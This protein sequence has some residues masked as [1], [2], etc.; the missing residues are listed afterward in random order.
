MNI[1]IHN[2]K[3]NK[4]SKLKFFYITIEMF[5]REINSVLNLMNEAIRSGFIVIVGDRQSFL[6]IIDSLPKGILFYKSASIVDEFYYNAFFKRGHKC[7][8]LDAEGLVVH[9]FK[10]FFFKNRLTKKNLE[11]LEYYFC[12]GSY[13]KKIASNLF[14]EFKNKFKTTGSILGMDWIKLKKKTAK[15]YL[16]FLT[17]FGNYN[18]ISGIKKLGID[19]QKRMYQMD[20]KTYGY[21]EKYYNY[22]NI[23]FKDYLEIIPLIADDI[24]PLKIIIKVHPAENIEPWKRIAKLKKNIILDLKNPTDHLISNAS[25]V[26]QSESTTALQTALIGG[27][28]VTY[29]PKSFM[30]SNIPLFLPK[31]VS[32]K[33]YD[34]KKLRKK[35]KTNF[36]NK[37]FKKNNN[38]KLQLLKKY[39]N[40]VE[41][42]NVDQLIVKYIKKIDVPFYNF[43]NYNLKKNNK[44]KLVFLF[45]LVLIKKLKIFNVF[46]SKKIN[47][48]LREFIVTYGQTKKILYDFFKIIRKKKIVNNFKNKDRY[49]INK[50]FITRMYKK[51]LRSV[52]I[53]ELDKRLLLFQ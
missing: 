14:K 36:K 30:N 37:N 40:N 41:N 17:S 10:N 7:V 18:H 4:I 53:T 22:I 46:Y 32:E 3:K 38:K 19:L 5:H 20:D 28:L 33:F 51:K 15:P 21:L 31:I 9:N 2:K 44:L 29:I 11:K 49:L 43:K 26:L 25:Q 50:K 6:K 1:K 47:F 8:C 35:I 13:Q 52:E 39:F 34:V 45:F 24:Y 16:L 42:N 23:L 48:F 12:A 27:K